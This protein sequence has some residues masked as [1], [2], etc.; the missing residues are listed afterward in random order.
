LPSGKLLCHGCGNSIELEHNIPLTSLNQELTPHIAQLDTIQNE[1][2][3]PFFY[4]LI[5]DEDSKGDPNYEV[6]RSYEGGRIQH[7]RLKKGVSP[8]EYRIFQ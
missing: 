3:P 7:I 1:Q 4:S 8:T 5:E 2:A 6:T